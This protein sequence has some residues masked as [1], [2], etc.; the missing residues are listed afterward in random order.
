MLNSDG[1]AVSV[2]FLTGGPADSI[3]ILY[4]N[5]NLARRGAAPSVPDRDR[6]GVLTGGKVRADLAVLADETS[7][8]WRR[9]FKTK[10]DLLLARDQRSQLL[11]CAFVRRPDCNFCHKRSA[12]FYAV[13]FVV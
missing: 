12:R 11:Q 5:L 6:N 2:Q 9:A 3:R 4:P 10:L 13:Y 8:A 1:S 7:F